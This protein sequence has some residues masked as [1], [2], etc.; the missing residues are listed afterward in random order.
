MQYTE[1]HHIIPKCLGGI[2]NYDNI[3]T[4]SYP[5]H[6]FAHYLLTL[7]YPN[8]KGILGAYSLM[9]CSNLENFKNLEN[10]R[11]CCSEKM[12]NTNIIY[13]EDFYNRKILSGRYKL[14][15]VEID[16]Y[17]FQATRKQLKDFLIENNIL[18][19]KKTDIKKQD[20]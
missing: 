7:I 5:E 15:N 12:K 9:K 20:V 8:N 17:K 18:C 16:N 2:D 19:F 10:I 3:I 6:C 13:S 1:N 14:Y 4:L 11:R